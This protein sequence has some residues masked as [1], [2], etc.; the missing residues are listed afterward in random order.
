MRRRTSWRSSSGVRHAGRRFARAAR[1]LP[2]A[3]VDALRYLSA[4]WEYVPQGWHVEDAAIEGWNDPSVA[5]AQEEHWPTLLRNLEGP[6]PLGVSHFPWSETRENRADHNAMMSFAY[7]LAL[8]ARKKDRLSMLDVGGGA[9]H[10]YLYSQ[11]LLPEVALEYHCQDLPSLCR[12]GRKLLPR[13][14]FHEAESEALG[15]HYDLVVASSSLH[16]F[17]DWRGVARRLA[18]AAEDLLYVARLQTVARVPSFVVVQRPHR[19]G[20]LTE[21]LSW[22]LNRDEVL[23]CFDEAGMDLRR[24]FVYAED[25]CVKGAPEQGTCRGFLFRRRSAAGDR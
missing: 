8:A 23:H 3:L 21:Y 20:Y 22:F 18:M 12:L 9:G 15:R 17:E 14:Q 5:K 11:A 24:E 7:V 13:V 2:P 16:Y 10:Y 6:G 1:Y 25:W 4:D 19:A